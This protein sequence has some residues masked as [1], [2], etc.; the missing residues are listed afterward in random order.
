MNFKDFYMTEG[1]GSAIGKIMAGGAIALGT[2]LSPQQVEAA[3]TKPTPAIQKLHTH[4]QKAEDANLVARII[5]AETGGSNGKTGKRV[6]PEERRLVASSIFNRLGKRDFGGAKT[7][8]GVV[9]SAKQ[10]S[11]YGDKN[12]SLWVMSADPS[13]IPANLK[14]AWEDSVKIAKELIAKS[15]KWTPGV[16]AYHDASINKPKKWDNKYWVYV[17]I[18]RTDNFTFYRVLPRKGLRS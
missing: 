2:M 16:V 11:A 15:G 5:F 13:K 9:T 8:T 4:D 18:K 14:G 3:R 6:T 1:L 12:N 17:P 10:Y 7:V